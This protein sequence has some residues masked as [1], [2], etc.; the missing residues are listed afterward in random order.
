MLATEA[1]APNTWED[2]FELYG[3][4]AWAL[5]SGTIGTIRLNR[6]SDPEACWAFVITRVGNKVTV[7]SRMRMREDEVVFPVVKKHSLTSAHHHVDA[8]IENLGRAGWSL[9]ADSDEHQT[10][11][12]INTDP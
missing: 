2:F 1:P 3:P 4:K 6:A 5:A 8:V 7:H 10:I 12:P 9:Q 11:A